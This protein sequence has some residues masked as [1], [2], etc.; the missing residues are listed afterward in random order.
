MIQYL[1]CT[2]LEDLPPAPLF[3]GWFWAF[4]QILAFH[5]TQVCRHLSKHFHRNIQ[6]HH[7]SRDLLY[8]SSLD[9]EPW[10]LLHVD[11]W[12][13]KHRHSKV[14][15]PTLILIIAAMVVSNFSEM[16]ATLHDTLPRSWPLRSGSAASVSSQSFSSAAL[17]TGGCGEVSLRFPSTLGSNKVLALKLSC[18][19]NPSSTEFLN[20]VLLQN[21]WKQFCCKKKCT[22]WS[23][24]SSLTFPLPSSSG[25]DSIAGS[26]KAALL[27]SCP[28]VVNLDVSGVMVGLDVL[29]QSMAVWEYNVRRLVGLN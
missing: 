27:I 8:A 13:C 15:P 10:I 12:P 2:F 22:S 11:N 19:F 1:W 23:L 21:S 28:P 6:S 9:I 5:Q 20:W 3:L 16:S 4:H 26:L 17:L 25:S 18:K 24:R 7:N 29:I 14:N